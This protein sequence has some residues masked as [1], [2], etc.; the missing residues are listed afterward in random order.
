M[1]DAHH[2]SPSCICIPFGAYELCNYFNKNVNTI[3][4]TQPFCFLSCGIECSGAVKSKRQQQSGHSSEGGSAAKATLTHDCDVYV[5][6]YITRFTCLYNIALFSYMQTCLHS[7]QER[8]P[9]KTAARWPA[10]TPPSS[11]CG[12][13]G[14]PQAETMQASIERYRSS[15]YT[16]THYAHIYSI[17]DHMHL[18]CFV[19][20]SFVSLETGPA[21]IISTHRGARRASRSR[22]G[23]WCATAR[24]RMRSWSSCSSRTW[25]VSGSGR[26]VRRVGE[27][28]RSRLDMEV[29]AQRR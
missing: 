11:W 2:Y 9:A 4:Q 27:T 7:K 1:I 17:L 24:C 15:Y 28:R 29:A 6:V 21:A 22:L 23:M 18:P 20:I 16:I 14:R 13:D 10:T 26:W 8:N 19:I 12:V 5:R 25:T 3:N